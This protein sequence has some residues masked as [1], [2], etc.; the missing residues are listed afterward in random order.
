MDESQARFVRLVRVSEA[1][2]PAP[3]DELGLVVRLVETR[4]Q[5]DQRRLAGSVLADQRET[6]ALADVEVDLLER[7]RAAEC[8]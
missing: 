4:Q 7:S 8:L 1:A 5:L 6:L 2:G 3:H